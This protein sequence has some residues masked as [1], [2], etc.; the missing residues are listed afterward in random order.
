[1]EDDK[2][3][4]ILYDAL[5][6]VYK[7][8]V[9][10]GVKLSGILLVVIGWFTV[11]KNP[12]PMLC[13]DDFYPWLTFVALGFIV[14]GEIVLILHSWVQYSKSGVIYASIQKI[15]D[16]TTLFNQYRIKKI[17]LIASVVGHFTMMFGIFFLILTKYILE[18][19]DTCK[20]ASQAT[21]AVIP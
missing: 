4:E 1:M 3:F 8:Y 7:D 2:K 19:P 18:K 16:D 12:L 5:K 14:F 11:R 15:E 21:R 9:D 17:M 6:D 13:Y 10:I 20:I